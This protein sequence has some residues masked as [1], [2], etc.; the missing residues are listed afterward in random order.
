V[1]SELEEP[2]RASGEYWKTTRLLPPPNGE[3]LVLP[4]PYFS[5]PRRFDINRSIRTAY[6]TALRESPDDANA[7]ALQEL[8]QAISFAVEPAS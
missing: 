8:A 5:L 3:T 4:H 7:L 1:Y 2:A 6:T